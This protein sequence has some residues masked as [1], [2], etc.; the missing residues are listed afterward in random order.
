METNNSGEFKKRLGF[1]TLLAMGVG[2]VIGDGIFLLMGEAINVAGPGAIFS[3][4]FAGFLQIAMMIALSELAVAVPSPG[5]MS[6]WVEKFIGKWWGFLAG[7]SYALGYVITGATCGIAIGRFTC[8]WFPSLDPTLWTIIFA[9]ALNGIFAVI[10]IIGAEL[11]GKTQLFLTILLVVIMAAFVVLGVRYVDLTHFD[12]MFTH[13]VEGFIDAIP[14]GVYAYMGA[15]CLTT[16]G[17][18]CRRPIDLG[19]ALVWSGV[20]FVILYGACQFVATGIVPM[21]EI[22]MDTSIFTVAADKIFGSAGGTILNIA[23]WLAAATCLLMGS[24]YVS[25]RV[26]YQLAKSKGLPRQFCVLGR[27]SGTPVFGI[28]ITY[29]AIALCTVV[30]YY[31]P[32]EVYLA[33]TNQ[34][35]I[36]FMIPW[37]LALVCA[38]IVRRR[39]FE[40]IKNCGWIQPLYPFFPIAGILGCIYTIYLAVMEGMMHMVITF[41]WVGIAAVYY[42]GYARKHYEGVLN[43]EQDETAMKLRDLQ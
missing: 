28:V 29:I 24:F 34:N 33:L 43:D 41:T 11:T 10:N 19:R 30:A 17:A 2:A 26:L 39:H 23:A 4:L 16:A 35:V 32:N 22:N 7:I 21:N 31:A 14:M 18:E 20:I 37:G 1:W 8:Y 6:L 27:K 15:V 38:F 5:A 9:L 40:L 3:F 12:P 25:S 13:G 42:F 36:A